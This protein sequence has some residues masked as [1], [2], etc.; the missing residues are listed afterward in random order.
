MKTRLTLIAACVMAGNLMAQ[1]PV[2]ISTAP[3][4]AEQVWYSLLNGEVGSGALNDWDLAFEVTGL[5]AGIRV[6][7]AKG[8]VAYETPFTFAQWDA[9]TSPDPN[10]WT[11]VDNDVTRWDMGALNHGNNMDLP[12]GYNVGWGQYNP[13]NHQMQGNRVYAIMLPDSTWKKLRI[14]SVI[15]GTFSFTYAAIDG[16]G[17]HDASFNKSA[18]AGKNFAYWSFA[19]N[20]AMDREPAT[21]TW[22]LVFTKYTDFVP[23]P[24][25][26]AGVLQNRSVTALQVD[27]V[28]TAAA[29][30]TSAPFSTDINIIGSDWKAYDMNAGAYTIVPDRTYF[31]KDIPG[32]IWKIIFTGYGG[33]ANG[34]MNFTQEL[35][36]AVG[37][38]DR[39]AQ[40]GTLVPYPNPVSNGEARMIVD[41]PGKEA[42]VVVFNAAGQQVLRQQWGGLSGL[43][44]RSLDVHALPRGMYTVRLSGPAFSTA[45]KLAVE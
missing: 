14:N 25:N 6:N 12:T 1:T 44:E 17:S 39:A 21:T 2:T 37:I 5:T 15:S 32:N 24:Y 45:A 13:A 34:N 40:E 8:M 19:T 22:D 7:T 36:S 38:K 3:G 20:A 9:L 30:W 33:G 16:S 11:R 42:T 4:N 43:T 18:F 27:G 26:V 29:E 10:A 41:V 35:A 23:T 28:P 31:V